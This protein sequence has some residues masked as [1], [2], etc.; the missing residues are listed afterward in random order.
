MPLKIGVIGAGKWGQNHV[1]IYKELGCELVGIADPDPA[2]V[3]MARENGT[4][5]FTDY[6]ELLPLVDAVSVVVPTNLH[7]KVVSDALSAGKHVMVEKPIATTYAEARKLIELA[8]RK[9]VVLMVGYLF[10]F[11]AAVL[12]LKRQLASAGKIQYITA[13]YMHSSKPP[14]KDCGVILN[15]TS[16]LFDIIN[17]VTEKKPKSVFCKKVNYLSPEREDCALIILDYG[18]FIANIEVS[19][20]HPLKK[21]DMWVIGAKEKIYADFLEQMVTRYPLIVE[22]DR[23]VSQKEINVE[24]RKNEPLKEELKCFL[25]MAGGRDGNRVEE[26]ELV[27]KMCEKSMESAV[28]GR[29]IKLEL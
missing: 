9:N 17:F 8:K 7:F 23:V 25:K 1:R 21:R 27:M 26:E 2:T 5:H 4:K 11:N 20:L 13:R 24:V 22:Q 19:W 6:M 28:S 16:H 12:E 3:A 14:R 15:F 29:E 18:D 10:R